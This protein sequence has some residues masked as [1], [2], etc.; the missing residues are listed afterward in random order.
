MPAF[1]DGAEKEP[2]TDR[3][4]VIVWLYGQEDFQRKLMQA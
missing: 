1:F 3:K 4:D 2:C